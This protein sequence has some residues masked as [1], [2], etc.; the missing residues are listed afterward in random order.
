LRKLFATNERV[1]DVATLIARLGLAFV[2]M[3]S[4]SSKL[5]NPMMAEMMHLDP[6]L[7]MLIGGLEV[8]SGLGMLLG[9]LTRLS[10]IYQIVILLGAI[11][12]VT[13]GNV[14]SPDAP[15]VWKD[16]GLLGLTIALLLF[17][18]GKYSVDAKLAK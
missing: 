3:F 6:S 12:I 4:G 13:G 5:L 18:P 9:L 11:F 15:A 7:W 16:P 17:G 14:G 2:F 10:A 1:A 8:L